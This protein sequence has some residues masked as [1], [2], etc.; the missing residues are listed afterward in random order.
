[1]FGWG[2]RGATAIHEAFPSCGLVNE[3]HFFDVEE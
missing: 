1:M 3:K 2:V